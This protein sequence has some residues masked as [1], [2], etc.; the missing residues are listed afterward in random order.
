MLEA[1]VDEEVEEVEEVEVAEEGEVV[2][3][4]VG[5]SRTAKRAVT[6]VGRGKILR[7]IRRLRLKRNGSRT[8]YKALSTFSTRP[9][10]STR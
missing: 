8:R 10:H 9:L 3:L 7:K 5:G 6:D 1:V 2:H 4:G